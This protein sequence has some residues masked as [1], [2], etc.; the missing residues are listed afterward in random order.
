MKP[1]IRI[2]GTPR[3]NYTIDR[4]KISQE[5]GA[6]DLLTAYIAG[7]GRSDLNEM[8][9][10]PAKI[11]WGNGITA[12]TAV[13]YVD[14]ISRLG[15]P[16]SGIIIMLLGATSAMRS[17][18]ARTFRRTT[19]FRIARSIVHPYRLSLTV[20]QYVSPL[21]SFMQTSESDWAALKQLADMTGMALVGSNTA[22]RMVDV[23]RELGRSRLRPVRHL[24][25]PAS[26]VQME[27]P[28]PV[29]FD[30]YEFTGIDALG[31]NFSVTGGPERGVKRHS[32]RNFA[33]LDDARNASLQ[34]EDRK[35]FYVRSLATFRG[36]DA[37]QVGDVVFVEGLRW[38]V[39]KVEAAVHTN[40]LNGETEMELH[41]STSTRPA[42]LE[43][44]SYPS[45]RRVGMDWVSSKQHE[46]EL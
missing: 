31:Q 38:F 3:H 36:N 32:G 30:R 33:S 45:S 24:P 8:K 15:G 26:F 2:Y 35:R 34:W 11:T 10:A 28:S 43:K 6:H 18:E 7:P 16:D 21:D 44:A 25:D 23:R 14:T 22:V 20:D 40:G 1:I 46:V 41:R 27:T 29:G 12:R 37:T 9:G 19:P 42:S 17:G 5:E 4:L 13:G 39:S